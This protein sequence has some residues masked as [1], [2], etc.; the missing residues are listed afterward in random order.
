MAG[1]GLPEVSYRA[2]FPHG[3]PRTLPDPSM[4][5]LA[6]SGG[7]AGTKKAIRLFHGTSL[8]KARN[9]ERWGFAPSERGSLG[10]GVYLAPDRE[11]AL[12]FARSA[13][14]H[15]SCDGALIEVTMRIDPTKVKHARHD[16]R[17]WQEQGYD[18]CRARRTSKSSRPGST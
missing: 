5:A 17:T 18:A 3:A 12:K 16:D 10:R 15:G 4:A 7:R 1:E 11:K 8:Q 13:N 6:L 2:A 14:W 9:I